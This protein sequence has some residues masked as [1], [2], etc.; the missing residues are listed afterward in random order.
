MN[1]VGHETF[2][3]INRTGTD[4]QTHNNQEKYTKT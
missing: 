1:H 3:E 2:Q 4:K